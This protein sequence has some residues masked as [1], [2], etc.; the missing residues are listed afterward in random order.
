MGDPIE[1]QFGNYHLV[2][3]VG[4]GGFG[5][6]HLG[7]RLDSDTEVAIKIFDTRLI[8]REQRDFL[9]EARVIAALNH[10]SIVHL[11]DSGIEGDEPFLVMNYA[12]GGT[13]R[14]RHPK[15]SCVP[16]QQV[17]EYVEPIASALD[18]AHEHGVIHRDIKPENLLLGSHGEVLLGDFGI[19]LISSAST[20]RSIKAAP[21]TVSYMAPEQIL[22]KPHR[23]SDQYALGIVVY[24]WLCGTL[25]FLGSFAEVGQQHLFAPPPSFEEQGVKIAPS[26]EAVVR[27]ALTKKPAER[28]LT[29][30]EFANALKESFLYPETAL[31]SDPVL[32]RTED[33]V[34]IFA[35]HAHKL[36]KEPAAVRETTEPLFP[37][38]LPAPVG[39]TPPPRRRSGLRRNV[40]GVLCLLL[41][42]VLVTSTALYGSLFAPRSAPLSP[43][44]RTSTVAQPTLVPT[45]QPTSVPTAQPTSAPTA[46]PTSAPTAQPTS[47]PTAISTLTLTPTLVPPLPSTP[48]PTPTPAGLTDWTQFGFGPQGGRYS[49][50]ENIIT[51]SNVSGLIQ[52]WTASTG[53]SFNSSVAG[54]PAVVNGV[55]YVGSDKL[56]AFNATTG[57]QVWT[58][59]TAASISGSPAVANGLV[60]IGS[61]KLYAFNATTGA[62]VWTASLSGTASS[63]TVINGVV[64]VTT[65]F[66]GTLSAFNAQTGAQLWSVALGN[67]LISNP[68]MANGIAYVGVSGFQS[69]ELE[70]FNAQTGALLWTALNGIGPIEDAPAIINGTLYIGSAD[71]HIYALNPQTGAQI[72]AAPTSDWVI[73][74]PAVANGVVYASTYSGKLE[75]FN[76]STG[77]QLWSMAVGGIAYCAPAVANGV[78]YVTSNDGHLYAL[79]AQTG[80]Q[81]LSAISSV[82]AT[83]SSTVVN[84]IVYFGS[85]DHN[86]YAFH[87][88]GH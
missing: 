83:T 2:K 40:I 39:T 6:V 21:G 23:A 3:L 84:G 57:A 59:S 44:P 10:P 45:A 52:D 60:Y 76:A 58:A 26:V 13:L 55:V 11:L 63:P 27:K 36:Q 20:S 86:L 9:Q 70:A 1:Q 72:W 75:A 15:G 47:V 66:S 14:Q 19:A 4:E 30:Q 69:G 5:K 29:V 79:N 74:P 46:Q 61:D 18:Y 54:S 73:E 31:T 35:Q 22:G 81:L 82:S 56:Y 85:K 33:D 28:F 17:V 34:V 68:S 50:Y 24:E 8:S 51:T 38:V 16:L 37:A 62:Q 71:D 80:V 77:A 32:P 41:L 87:L 49:N 78:V 25:P 48:T 64:Y 67:N 42:G 7:K 65:A 43:I 88:P 12:P 53:G